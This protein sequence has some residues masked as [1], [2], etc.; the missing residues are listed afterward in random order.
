MKAI[1]TIL[2]VVL[3]IVAAMYFLVPAEL[4]ADIFPRT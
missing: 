2:G 1:V 4:A 3:L